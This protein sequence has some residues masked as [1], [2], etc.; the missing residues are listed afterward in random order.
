MLSCLQTSRSRA[1]Y[2]DR[3]TPAIRITLPAPRRPSLLLTVPHG[4][5][6]RLLCATI[7]F[8]EIPLLT[9]IASAIEDV[10]EISVIT[11]EKR[12]L[13]GS[14]SDR[15]RLSVY[16]LTL[17]NKPQSRVPTFDQSAQR[18]ALHVARHGEFTIVEDR[19]QDIDLACQFVG[20]GPR[21]D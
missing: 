17:M 21:L 20:R 2:D 8:P 7:T 1:N 13:S 4:V 18:H 6:N 10:N 9:F 5:F 15:V 16:G 3:R 19:R 11:E 14:H 12:I